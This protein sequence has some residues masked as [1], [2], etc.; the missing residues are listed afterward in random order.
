MTGALIVGR[1]IPAGRGRGLPA[2]DLPTFH[3]KDV[4]M[5]IKALMFGALLLLAS[6]TLPW[7]QQKNVT[8]LTVAE[9]CNAYTAALR[10]LTPHKAAGLLSEEEIATVNRANQ[11]TDPI[12]SGE[13]PA[14]PVDAVARVSNAVTTVMLIVAT[15]ENDK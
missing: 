8:I 6:C 13:P 1:T 7:E 15:E 10:V 3:N 11:V 2:S 4:P 5:R 14:D 12:C 9:A